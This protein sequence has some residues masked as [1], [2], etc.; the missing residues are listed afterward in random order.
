LFGFENEMSSGGY[1]MRL[2]LPLRLGPSNNGDNLTRSPIL[3]NLMYALAHKYAL[4]FV[5]IDD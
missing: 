2:T 1:V 5:I 4:S 3:N